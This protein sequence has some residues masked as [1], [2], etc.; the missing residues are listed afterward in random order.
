MMTHSSTHEELNRSDIPFWGPKPA[1]LTGTRARG[2]R[3]GGGLQQSV[4]S[5]ATNLK[6]IIA[7]KGG[8]GNHLAM[9]LSPE[10]V[11]QLPRHARRKI[12]PVPRQ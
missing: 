2:G 12:V 3:G 4:F 8:G 7:L 1:I 11:L 10:F 6:L 9:A 5:P